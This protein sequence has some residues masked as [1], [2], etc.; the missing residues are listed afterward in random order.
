MPLQGAPEEEQYF[1]YFREKTAYQLSGGFDDGVW[2]MIVL[3][4]GRSQPTIQ[5]LISSLAALGKAKAISMLADTTENPLPHLEHAYQRYGQ[6]VRDIRS[7]ASTSGLEAVQTLLVASLLIYVF[8]ILQGDTLAA[9]SHLQNTFKNLIL[10]LLPTRGPFPYTHLSPITKYTSIDSDLLTAF[11]RLDVQLCTHLLDTQLSNQTFFSTTS[12]AKTTIIGIAYTIEPAT[13][14]GT[15]RDLSTA[16][17][18]LEHLQQ[19]CRSSLASKLRMMSRYASLWLGS[20]I[21]AQDIDTDTDNPSISEPNTELESQ[22]LQLAQWKLA[23]LPLF[24]HALTPQ[25]ARNFVPAHSLLVQASTTSVIFSRS[26]QSW[27]FSSCTSTHQS[28]RFQCPLT[29]NDSRSLAE[30]EMERETFQEIINLCRT[31]A[32]HESFIKDFVI[33]EGFLRSLFAVG[34]CVEEDDVKRE[35]LDVL[36]EMKGRREGVWDVEVVRRTVAETLGDGGNQ[37]SC[38]PCV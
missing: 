13:I 19:R 20:S 22:A 23:F 32:R 33:H 38:R 25:G 5:Y 14:T 17:R 29:A 12:K 9:I 21:M 37:W 6:A 1:Q 10:Q 30:K 26:S 11:A 31:A 24:N 8:E 28:R 36:S 3:Q 18:Y 4:A 15:Y 7:I 2:N 16:R 27:N 35:V 34:L